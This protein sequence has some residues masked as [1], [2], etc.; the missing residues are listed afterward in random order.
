MMGNRGQKT[1]EQGTEY[2]AASSF[3]KESYLNVQQSALS[4]DHQ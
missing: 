2:E 1:G 3:I 4:F